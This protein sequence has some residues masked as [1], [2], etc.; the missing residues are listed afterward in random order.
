MVYSLAGNRPQSNHERVFSSW[1]NGKT[2][3][4]VGSNVTESEWSE[5]GIGLLCL[6]YRADMVLRKRLKQ[7]KKC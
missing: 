2:K 5:L 6:S 7:I 3:N 4:I 1:L